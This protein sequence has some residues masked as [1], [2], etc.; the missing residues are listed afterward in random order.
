VADNPYNLDPFTTIT[1]I[2]FGS[3]WFVASAAFGGTDADLNTI[4]CQL[5]FPGEAGGTPG[6]SIIPPGLE[7]TKQ[8]PYTLK[9]VD[10]ITPIT[11]DAGLGLIGFSMPTPGDGGSFY[12]SLQQL[13]KV[14]FDVSFLIAGGGPT[15]TML[16]QV[17]TYRSSVFK[18]GTV[19]VGIPSPPTS[20]GHSSFQQGAGGGNT[21]GPIAGTWVFTIDPS[22]LQVTAN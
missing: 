13:P 16:L 10:L 18:K 4:S 8:F 12:L 17:A 19:L 14:A 2:S 9:A 20:A 21:G 15:A 1:N 22:T 5:N 6:F 11:T 3:D 7:P